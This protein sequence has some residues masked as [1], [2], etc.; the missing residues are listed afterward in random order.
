MVQPEALPAEILLLILQHIRTD[1]QQSP[2]TF[3]DLADWT[4]DATESKRC[5]E[6]TRTLR[7]LMLT[8]RHLYALAKPFFYRN[9]LV[10][11]WNI[12]KR[13]HLT[14]Q[15][16]QSISRNPELTQYIHSAIINTAHFKGYDPSIPVWGGGWQLAVY[17]TPDTSGSTAPELCALLRA[18]FFTSPHLQHLT[19]V[20]FNAWDALLNAAGAGAGAPEL[21]PTGTSPLTHLTLPKCGAKEPALASLLAWPRALQSLHYDAVT[22]AWGSHYHEHARSPSE[23]APWTSAAFVRSLQL[24]KAS[25]TELSITRPAPEHEGLTEGPRVDLSGFPALRVL[26]TLDVFLVGT[27]D[28][29]DAWR[30]L[31]PH[32]EVLEVFYDDTG[33]EGGRLFEGYPAD[34]GF[35]EGD[36][37]GHGGVDEAELEQWWRW[38]WLRALLEQRAAASFPNLKTVRL[39]TPEDEPGHWDDRDGRGKGRLWALPRIIHD[40]ATQAGV[41]VEVWI[42]VGYPAKRIDYDAMDIL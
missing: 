25:L 28:A 42:N 41:E 10:P 15:F 19:I 29:V 13:K 30:G 6:R 23:E 2:P 34:D 4:K 7:S 18:L 14:W 9:I 40:L 20:G 22:V 11:Q 21:L 39:Y 26:R 24:Q 27:E 1:R 12:R 5:S 33:Y 8:S 17:P 16:H 35:V 36:E 32:L 38:Q 37:Q 31:P 3:F